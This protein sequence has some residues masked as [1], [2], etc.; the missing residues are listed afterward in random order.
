MDIITYNN[1]TCVTFNL[2]GVGAALIHKE[3]K[4]TEICR[5]HNAQDM[6]FENISP[7]KKN[8][9]GEIIGAQLGNTGGTVTFHSHSCN[10]VDAANE[11]IE[12]LVSIGHTARYFIEVE[13][14]H[15]ADGTPYKTPQYFIERVYKQT[16][17]QQ[18]L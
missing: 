13:K 7:Y 1:R 14:T 17:K 16:N 9:L 10:H 8:R 11:L 5:K 12:Y 3:N 15:R 4:V 18:P 2:T 6:L